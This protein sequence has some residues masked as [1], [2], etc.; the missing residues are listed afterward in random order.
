VALGQ[1][2]QQFLVLAVRV[3]HLGPLGGGL[4]LPVR[5]EQVDPAVEL[6]A[7][8]RIGR[9]AALARALGQARRVA[10]QREPVAQ[11]GAQVAAA[12]RSQPALACG[13]RSAD[14]CAQP[15]SGSTSAGA[16]RALAQRCGQKTGR[17]CTAGR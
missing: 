2:G 9:A 4:A 5:V 11:C 3:V 12:V 17:L 16:L 1:L 14:Q 8:Q 7:E 13:R 10:R 15:R 6:A